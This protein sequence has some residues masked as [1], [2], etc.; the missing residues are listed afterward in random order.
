MDSLGAQIKEI[1][2]NARQA[3]AREALRRSEIIQA[4]KAEFK[5]QIHKLTQSLNSDDTEE[6]TDER[7]AAGEETSDVAFLKDVK[8]FQHLHLRV[9]NIER[10]LASI[11]DFSPQKERRTTLSFTL[12]PSNVS[13]MD[14]FNHELHLKLVTILNEA[15]GLKDLF[16][17][18]DD[19]A[20]TLPSL[21]IPNFG[22]YVPYHKRLHLLEEKI[23]TFA[24]QSQVQTLTQELAS[25][26]VSLRPPTPLPKSDPKPSPN[27][28]L[29]AQVSE[30]RLSIEDIRASIRRLETA[31]QE[32][33]F[34]LSPEPQATAFPEPDPALG[35]D[36]D[37][38]QQTLSQ[39][40][41]NLSLRALRSELE[42]LMR[43]R[44][45]V[46]TRLEPNKASLTSTDTE[47]RMES[48]E[49]KLGYYWEELN[50]V[51]SALADKDKAT[52]KLENHVIQTT[53]GLESNLQRL[54][55]ELKGQISDVVTMLDKQSDDPEALKNVLTLKI[56]MMKLQK[57]LRELGNRVDAIPREMQV[58]EGEVGGEKTLGMVT[59]KVDS[60]MRGLMQQFQSLSSE[61][62][63]LKQASKKQVENTAAAHLKHLE[64]VKTD[65]G[66]VM[67]KVNEGARLNQRDYDMISELFML[68][69]N[70]GEKSA[71]NDKVNKDDLR[72]A[73][74]QLIQRIN[75]LK[76]SLYRLQFAQEDTRHH[77]REAFLT[78]GHAS[79]E[80]LSCGNEAI[81]M[82]ETGVRVGPGFSRLLGYL[83]KLV[84]EKEGG[85]ARTRSELRGTVT[86]RVRA[87]RKV[88]LQLP[89]VD[90][91]TRTDDVD[92]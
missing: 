31:F 23:Q 54:R 24:H 89:Q 85:H 40:Q 49:A 67:A 52:D 26:R 44:Q 69:E 30:L 3:E 32:G 38:V 75:D 51:K 8:R 41:R 43:P 10:R 58:Q 48:M 76:A 37:L 14:D 88:K 90:K 7:R 16:K 82:R 9:R 71:L 22:S 72:K 29:S 60:D 1:V 59:R 62:L 4:L 39:M 5:E 65:V 20:E 45:S 17:R 11:G 66:V 25:L 15:N 6:P 73:S 56:V 84:E 42:P 81:A 92:T 91:R 47:S 57:D 74:K 79:T 77:A 21:D 64:E 28:G 12:D 19:Q 87:S 46:L 53:A 80:C 70:K 2:A 83:G 61:V 68:V 27:E 55:I 36:L 33:A 35:R 18:V 78:K 86:D 63:E 13:M 34:P 50:K